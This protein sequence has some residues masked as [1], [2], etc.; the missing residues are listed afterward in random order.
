MVAIIE[1]PLQHSVL[2]NISWQTYERIL[3]EIGESH[4]RLTYQ[5]GKMEFM[6]LSF[7][8]ESYGEWIGR[9]IFFFALAIDAPIAS[10]GSTTLKQSMQQ[11]GLEPDRCFWIKHEKAMRGKKKWNA[12]T[13]PPP[14]LALEIDI[15]SSWLDR[16]AIYAALAVP[17]IWRFDGETLKVLILGANGK[18]RQK[19]KSL[20]FP[21][22][23]MDR[24]AQFVAK[25]GTADEVSLIR[26]FTEWAR[27]DVMPQQANGAVRSKEPRTK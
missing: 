9:L 21:T 12:K 16:L 27:T 5:D 20:A 10:G 14:D 8:H 22:L 17:E 11:V 6:T 3:D 25:L 13:D 4:Y 19:A 15:T 26:E 7:E 24:F 23:P 18:Y 1:Q 2:P